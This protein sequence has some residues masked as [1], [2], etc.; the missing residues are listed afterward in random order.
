LFCR[1]LGLWARAIPIVGLLR[2]PSVR[3]LKPI[4]TYLRERAAMQCEI[5]LSGP[6]Q[7]KRFRFFVLSCRDLES[8]FRLPLVHA[9]RQHYSTCYIRLKRRPVVWDPDATEMSILRFLVYV[10]RLKQGHEINVYFNTTNTSFPLLTALLRLIAPRGLWCLDMHDD[11]LYEST[12][13][14]RLRESIAVAIMR[15]F[16]HV[17]VCAAPTLLELFPEAR[18]LGNASHILPLPR[19]AAM[20]NE[21]LVIASFDDRF[22]FDF[23]S[24]VA[25]LCAETQ[26][27]LY[28]WVSLNHGPTQQSL[29]ALRGRHA[30]IHYHGPYTLDDLPIILGRYHISLAPYCTGIRKAHFI[31]PLRF[32]HCLNAGLE[33]ISTDIP[34]ARYMSRY[35]H[36]APDPRECAAMLA[37]LR[38]GTLTRPNAYSPITWE[39]KRERLVEIISNALPGWARKPGLRH[40][41]IRHG[42]A[43]ENRDS[44]RDIPAGKKA[45]GS[46]P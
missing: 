34:Q 5:D 43:A 46:A 41:S 1:Q 40:P 35:L 15:A 37:A 6:S 39:H 10:W 29:T 21:V 24:E 26:F 22:D 11:L 42:L 14:R 36:I 38:R 25:D 27:H 3:Q 28:G 12:G 30:N 18:H 20:T 19:P 23:M 8:D 4:S 33:L 16:S 9:L 13:L 17:V 7:T 31:D 45:H 44:V 2:P 32:Y